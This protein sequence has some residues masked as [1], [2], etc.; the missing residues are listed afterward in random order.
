V[1]SSPH[2]WL[3]WP[4]ITRNLLPRSFTNT[5]KSGLRAY[6]RRSVRVAHLWKLIL[7]NFYPERSLFQIFIALCS[8]PRFALILLWYLLTYERGK[9]L[10]RI[11]LIIGFLRTFLFGTWAYV[12][13][14]EGP[15]VHEIVGIGYLFCTVPW[16]LGIISMA[17]VNPRTRKYR[18]IVAGCLYATWIPMIFFFTQHKRGV[19]GGIS[20]L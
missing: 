14:T 5:H 11:L 10:P 2:W 7:G 15:V 3:E 6:P 4:C 19:P 9:R 17:P 16:T 18:K 8:G 1:P 13:S 12:T 20:F